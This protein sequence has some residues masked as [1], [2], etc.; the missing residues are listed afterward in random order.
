MTDAVQ[1]ALIVAIPPTIVAVGG[2]V[3][4]LLN[5]KQGQKIEFKV[6]GK[7]DELLSLTRSGAHA[8]GIAEGREIG[9]VEKQAR[10]TEAERVEDRADQKAQDLKT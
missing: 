8:E 10:V 1:I 5:R 3:V 2:L 9:V 6:D 7:M 4:S